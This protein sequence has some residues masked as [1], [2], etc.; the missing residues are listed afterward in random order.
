MKKYYLIPFIMALFVFVFPL[1]EFTI[2]CPDA[3]RDV[4]GNTTCTSIKMILWETTAALSLYHWDGISST[5]LAFEPELFCCYNEHVEKFAAD[6]ANYKSIFPLLI[7]GGI[8]MIIGVIR[9]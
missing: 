9:K 7:T 1:A 5:S 2:D 3:Y 4:E 6:E 8:I